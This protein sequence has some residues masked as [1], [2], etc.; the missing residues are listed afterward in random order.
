MNVRE[1]IRTRRIEDLVAAFK[2]QE[3]VLERQLTPLQ[4]G[5]HRSIGNDDPVVHCIQQLLR[6][7]WAGDGLNIKRK[8]RHLN[9]LRA[10]QYAGRCISMY[11]DGGGRL[12]ETFES[13]HGPD[14]SGRASLS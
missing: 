5:A 10:G 2:A 1:N 9:R 14:Q 11:Y 7:D 12:P 8:T 4:H 6:T 3:V 13:R